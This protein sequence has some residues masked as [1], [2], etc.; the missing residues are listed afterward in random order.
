MSRI[1]DYAVISDSRFTLQT[2]GAGD[3]D[4]DFDF[5]LESGAHLGSRAVLL[6]DLFV[7]DSSSSLKFEVKI[8]GSVQMTRTYSSF[9]SNTMHEVVDANV[10][11]SGANANN[12]EFRIASGTGRL[13]IG[14]VVLFYQRDV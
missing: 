10:L 11:K 2:A 5:G 13:E 1:A 9:R 8:N 12:I 3:T 7:D 6:F 4:K 14:D